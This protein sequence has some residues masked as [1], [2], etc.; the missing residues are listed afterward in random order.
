MSTQPGPVPHPGPANPE[1]TPAPLAP[2][3]LPPLEEFPG[4]T[5]VMP[6]LNEEAN[7]AAAVTAVLNQDYPGDKQLVV[8]IGPCTDS[9]P[10]VAA[11]IRDPRLTV[12]DNPSGDTPTGLNLAITHARHPVIIRVDA[13]SHLSTT[14]TRAAVATLRHTG[15]AN[16]GGLMFARGKR[17]FQKAVA[18]AYMSRLGLGGPAYHSGDAAGEAESA[19]L[20][21]FRAQVF[22]T[23]GGFDPT[24]SR[25]Q[26]WE[27]NLRIREAGGKVWF[28]P[29]MEVTYWPRTTWTK[30]A[31]QFFATGVWRAEIV[32]RHRFKN[33]V[34]YF[35]PP[36]LVAGLGAAA[37]VGV[38]DLTGVTR[39]WSSFFRRGLRLVYVPVSLYV[40]AIGADALRQKDADVTERAWYA[41]VLPT[42]HISWG[43]GF[44]RG[45]VTGA[46]SS[47]VDRSR[48]GDT[49]ATSS[50]PGEEDTHGK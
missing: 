34:R 44:L 49:G 50:A 43:A 35:V 17:P 28:T 19:Y 45:L 23:L 41:T 40:A 15:A 11:S 38:L 4:V 46:D 22:A 42:M 5:Y 9:T 21:A 29:D 33:G 3:H 47:V 31:Q 27:L 30:L 1:P 48:H 6:V 16:C 10:Q 20:G 8:A 25:G 26:D 14:Y 18:R 2:E 37:A 12:V 39:R 36:V 24:L 7:L 32:R 13:H